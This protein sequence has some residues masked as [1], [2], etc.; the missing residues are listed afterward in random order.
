MHG[1]LSCAILV[2]QI[3]VANL[4]QLEI[5]A[6]LPTDFFHCLGC[7]RVF[8]ETDIGAQTRR[9][10]RISY[11]PQMMEEIQKLANLVNDL[12]SRYER[13]LNICLID[14][15]SLEGFFKSIRYWIRRYPTFILN[16]RKIAVGWDIS[17]LDLALQ[18]EINISETRGDSR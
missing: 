2:Y 6:P 17:K 13:Q 8:S 12:S 11:P 14:P 16:R 9:E 18:R 4:S 10:M 5:F 3:L 7:E 1:T 15:Q